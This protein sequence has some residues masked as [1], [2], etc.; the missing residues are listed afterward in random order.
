MAIAERAGTRDQRL[1]VRRARRLGGA[2]ASPASSSRQP[3][4]AFGKGVEAS[5][6]A[7]AAGFDAREHDRRR[8]RPAG[9]RRG[10]EPQL[11]PMA[12]GSGTVDGRAEERKAATEAAR[13]EIAA[14]DPAA[15]V[16]P[17]ARD[18]R[19]AG[20]RACRRA[21]RS[22][23]LHGLVRTAVYQDRA[24][25]ERYLERVARFAAVEPD[26]TARRG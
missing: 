12:T 26:P 14:T 2:A 13:T 23:I 11:L 16:G 21:A 18:A 1:A 25:A 19:R 7:F 24:Y 15:L 20:A 3:I 4:R 6:A 8:R 5:L 10:I 9:V 17:G 22:M